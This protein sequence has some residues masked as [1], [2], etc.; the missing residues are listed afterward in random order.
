MSSENKFS[1]LASLTSSLPTTEG[2]VESETMAPNQILSS[3]EGSRT[4]DDVDVDS[5]NSNGEVVFMQDDDPILRDPTS[6]SNSSHLLTA[7]GLLTGSGFGGLGM[8]GGIGGGEGGGLFDQVDREE[9]EKERLALEAERNAKLAADAKRQLELEQRRAQEARESMERE[10]KEEQLR[11]QQEQQMAAAAAAAE[12][13][14][15][16]MQ[17]LSLQDP[18]SSQAHS[19]PHVMGGAPTTTTINSMPHQAPTYS[20]ASPMLPSN[21]TPHPNAYPPHHQQ[22]MQQQ[23]TN[24]PNQ[25]VLAPTQQHQQLQQPPPPQPSIQQAGFGGSYYYSTSGNVQ[26]QKFNSNANNMNVGV[27]DPTDPGQSPG[28]NHYDT[29]KF[30]DPSN[31]NGNSHGNG[32]APSIPNSVSSTTSSYAQRSQLRQVNSPHR[33]MPANPPPPPNHHGQDFSNPQQQQQQ[34]QQQVQHP[35]P[36]VPPDVTHDLQPALFQHY[37]PSTFKPVHGVITITDPI[38]VQSPGVFSGPPYWTYAVTVRDLNVVEGQEEYSKVVHSV[39]RRFRHF[40]ALE[41]RL[42]TDRP[43]SILPPRYVTHMCVCS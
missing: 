40:V 31:G 37:D 33:I 12:A 30:V 1:L 26:Q 32:N 19:Y 43:G 39:R 6:K 11:Q 34:Q 28:V 41:E 8:G 3:N 42:R 4:D 25:H 18:L 14:T 22:Q 23:S 35:S 36:P 5:D 24:T 17:D 27:V 2:T 13:N 16:N 7:S 29:S 21:T 15:R 20:N 10:L 9:E 38:L